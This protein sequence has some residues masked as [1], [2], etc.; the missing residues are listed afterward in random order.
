MRIRILD[1]ESSLPWIRDPAWKNSDPGLISRIRNTATYSTST[2]NFFLKFTLVASF[3]P[4]ADVFCGAAEGRSARLD[5]H[6]QNDEAL[7][8][9]VPGTRTC[10]QPPTFSQLC[11]VWTDRTVPFLSFCPEIFRKLFFPFSRCFFPHFPS[12]FTLWYLVM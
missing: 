12:L 2:N 9:G 7:Q 3:S 6:G 4:V 8:P 1:T 11:Q 10:T 5:T